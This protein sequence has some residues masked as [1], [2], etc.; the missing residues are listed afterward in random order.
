MESYNLVEDTTCSVSPTHRR[1]QG[2]ERATCGYSGRRSASLSPLPLRSHVLTLPPGCA[3]PV[4][5]QS[6]VAAARRRNA[7]SRRRQRAG[8]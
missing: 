6:H 4:C 8:R 7:Q 1:E 5:A 3:G 2:E